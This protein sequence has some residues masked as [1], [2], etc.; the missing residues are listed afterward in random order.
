MGQSVLPFGGSDHLL[1]GLERNPLQPQFPDL[2]KEVVEIDKL[3]G[4]EIFKHIILNQ[5][6]PEVLLGD[7]SHCVHSV[8]STDS[9]LSDLVSSDI[10][11]F[12]FPKGCGL[13]SLLCVL[14]SS[15]PSVYI[16]TKSYECAEEG[17]FV[18]ARNWEASQ[19]GDTC[20]LKYT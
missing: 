17:V 3:Q 19:R 7:L 1:S 13:R 8:N 11:C 15:I 20:F 5:H 2:S 12:P 10:M 18:G 4:T 14:I 6:S 16:S 9:L